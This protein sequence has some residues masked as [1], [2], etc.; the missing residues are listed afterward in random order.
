MARLRCAPPRLAT[1]PGRL[2]T[3][4]TAGTGFRRTDGRSAAARGY[5]AAW[6]RLRLAH[7]AAHPFCV[8]CQQRGRVTAATEVHH[9][10]RFIGLDDPLRLDPGNCESICEP[11]HQRESARQANGGV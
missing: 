5:D 4:A 6:R 9:I 7:L 3:G 2:G 8:Q 10:R 1:A 11:C